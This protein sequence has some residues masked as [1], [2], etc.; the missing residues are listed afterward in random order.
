MHL[1]STFIEQKLNSTHLTHGPS[2]WVD[3]GGW[4]T[5][6]LSPCYLWK[7]QLPIA[8]VNFLPFEWFSRTIIIYCTNNNTWFI[9][10]SL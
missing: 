3:N 2:N 6:L 1:T 5:T 9:H 10:W 4:R 8:T 7:Q